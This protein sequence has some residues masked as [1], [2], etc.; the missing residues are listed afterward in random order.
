MPESQR[1]M[2]HHFQKKKEE[3][4][5]LVQRSLKL[6]WTLMV[7]CFLH[8]WV[9]ILVNLNVFISGVSQEHEII[10]RASWREVVLKSRC[11]DVMVRKNDLWTYAPARFQQRILWVNLVDEFIADKI[12]T[13]LDNEPV[14]L[15]CKSYCRLFLET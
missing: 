8:R 11:D 13:A 3:S 10:R 15:H 4:L 9:E 2:F 1:Y 12:R 6:E 14:G 7:S 5:W